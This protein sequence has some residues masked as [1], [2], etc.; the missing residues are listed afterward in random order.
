[1]PRS[2]K[3]PPE[4]I[5]FQKA[6]QRRMKKN[7]GEPLPVNPTGRRREN[8]L[9]IKPGNPVGAVGKGLTKRA[10]KI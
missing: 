9:H 5:K 4:K 3:V 2:L 8:K 10:F 1:M 6:A 7:W